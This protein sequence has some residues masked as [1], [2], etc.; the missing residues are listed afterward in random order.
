MRGLCCTRPVRSLLFGTAVVVALLLVWPM[1]P[2]AQA[3]DARLED[4][5]N[6]RIAVQQRLD[7]VLARLDQAQAATAQVEQ[8]VATLRS[9]AR[10]Y[11]ARARR[12]GNL[13]ESRAR[14]A[15]KGGEMPVAFSLLGAASS[16]E[17]TARARVLS[18]LA[19]RH[20]A[21]SEQATGDQ[22][23]ASAAAAQINAAVADLRAREAE[24]ES[25]R[26]DVSAALAE[27]QAYEIDVE[28]TIASEVAAQERAARQRA[29]RQAR[30][31]AVSQPEP[32]A[33]EP[34]D[35]PAAEKAGAQPAAATGGIAC[36]VGQPRSYSDTYGAPRSGGR[37]HLGTDILAPMG[38][39][40]YAYEAGTITRMDGNSLGGISLY[41]QGDSGNLYYYT[42]LSGYTAGAGVG[43]HV[44]AGT[45][46]ASNGDSGN[47]A[48][49]PHLHFEV[50]PG[51]GS[52]VNPYPFVY[53]ACG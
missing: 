15:Y 50:M 32:E 8:R 39:P 49:I 1:S 53:R 13:L 9:E 42:H 21:Q 16:E 45:H 14:D 47:A 35:P 27:A 46:I 38:T 31:A 28:R 10:S 20:K 17:A 44:A 4:A 34:D 5:E 12:A 52:N 2:P 51:G 43:R 40:I 36:P 41:L 7:D 22:V 25:A 33:P 23:R 24:M 18:L 26:R 6:K 19:L 48:G 29:A 3:A 11:G 37:S 30:V